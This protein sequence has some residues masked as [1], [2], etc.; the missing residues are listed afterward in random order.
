MYFKKT[1]AFKAK[2]YNGP[3]DGL[4]TFIL[5]SEYD[6]PPEISCLELYNLVELSSPL[7]Q[8]YIQNRNLEYIR[9]A[10]YCSDIVLDFCDDDDD[11]E[12]ETIVIYN[13]VEMLNYDQYLI[14]Y[15][16][17]EF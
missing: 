3:A 9:T 17:K 14:Q 10:I 16:N 8:I 2:Y 1:D 12:H 15:E 4:D 11:S 7:G 6:H 5:S 13:F